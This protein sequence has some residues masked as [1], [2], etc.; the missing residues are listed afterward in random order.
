MCHPE[1]RHEIDLIDVKFVMLL[2]YKIFRLMNET[3]REGRTA[4]PQRKSSAD[5]SIWSDNWRFD[6]TF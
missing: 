1:H 6:S 3:C 2:K 4:R 5:E